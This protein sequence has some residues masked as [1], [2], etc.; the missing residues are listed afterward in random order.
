MEHGEGL[1]PGDRGGGG[2]QT[3]AHA[4]GQAVGAGPDDGLGVVVGGGNVG[5][6]E[7]AGDGGLAQGVIQHQHEVAPLDG[8]VPAKLGGGDAGDDAVLIAVLHGGVG[9]VAGGHVVVDVLQGHGDASGDAAGS[10]GDGAGAAVARGGEQAVGGDGANAAG[11]APGHSGGGGAQGG[12][13]PVGTGGGQLDALTRLHGQGGQ[14]A[15]VG[16]GYRELGQGGDHVDLGGAGETQGVGVDGNGVGARRVSGGVHRAV[17]GT[18]AAGGKGGVG[19]PAVHRFGSGVYRHYVAQGDRGAGQ[20]HQTVLLQSQ[21]GGRAGAGIVGDQ[22]DEGGAASGAAAGG[23][24]LNGDGIGAGQPGAEDGGAAAVQVHRPDAALAEQ[25]VGQVLLAQTAGVAG[26]AA[27]HFIKDHGAVGL[28]AQSGAGIAAVLG[29]GPAGA[30][31]N[32]AVVYHDVPAAAGPLG[33]GQDGVGAGGGQGDQI[34]HLVAG[35]ELVVAR[36]IGGGKDVVIRSDGHR[37]V[38]VKHLGDFEGEGAVDAQ[39]GALLLVHQLHADHPAAGVV[40]AGGDG[41]EVLIIKVQASGGVPPLVEVVHGGGGVGALVCHRHAHLGGH[42]QLHAAARPGHGVAAFRAGFV[43]AVFNRDAD[44][45]SVP[46][47]KVAVDAANHVVSQAFSIADGLVDGGRAVN[48]SG[49]LDHNGI[50]L[51]VGGELEAV[52]FHP[53]GGGVV[54]D[55]VGISKTIGNGLC[56]SQFFGPCGGERRGNSHDHR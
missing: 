25:L 6:G 27:V 37:L 21:A 30:V 7:G 40:G 26:L 34:A 46:V 36:L 50:D 53:A 24:A 2:E 45:H 39:V 43:Y 18:Q 19:D 52:A 4:G 5:E 9:P 23:R 51:A 14:G 8:Q 20:D 35:E 1:L 56:G 49:G 32:G 15:A 12:A 3:V 29:V 31:G 28:H 22:E 55:G 54:R 13:G 11:D 47:E 16:L 38:S 33:P 44:G 41:G 10:G 17:E 48:G 42:G